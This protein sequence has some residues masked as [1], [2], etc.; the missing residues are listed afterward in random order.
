MRRLLFRAQHGDEDVHRSTEMCSGLFARGNN[1][2]GGHN[3]NVG[4]V[5]V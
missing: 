4:C 3:L 5:H 2:A 1:V